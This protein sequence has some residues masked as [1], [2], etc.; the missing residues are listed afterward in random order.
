MGD[1]RGDGPRRSRAVTLGAV[2]LAIDV[3]IP[4][5]PVYGNGQTEWT[6]VVS[7]FPVRAQLATV[8]SIYAGAAVVMIGLASLARGRA[9]LG[10]GVFLAAGGFWRFA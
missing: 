8:I 2:A 7:G 3:A 9:A 4:F 10:A 6:A 1:G 5:L